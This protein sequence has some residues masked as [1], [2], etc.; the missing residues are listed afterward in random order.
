MFITV[1]WV[2]G[3]AWCDSCTEGMYCIKV[4]S[5]VF[6]WGPGFSRLQFFVLNV[7]VGGGGWALR[8]PSRGEYGVGV[9]LVGI[10]WEIME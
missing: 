3:G 1:L 4:V 7:L 6:R 5:R 10:A 9:V 8:F 2:C